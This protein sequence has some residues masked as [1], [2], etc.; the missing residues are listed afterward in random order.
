M[1]IK[2]ATP[3]LF[4]NG[5]AVE[6]AA[7]YANALGGTV[8]SLMRYGDMDNC[9]DADKERV[10][11]GLVTIGE[12]KVMLSDTHSSVSPAGSEAATLAGSNVRVA[13]DFDSPEEMKKAF[14]ALAVGG[15]VM[16]P[17]MEV[18]WGAFGMLTD[19]YEIC[20]M[21]NFSKKPD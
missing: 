5:Q 20:W 1:T 8:A 17:I 13:L 3:Y 14:A 19:K 2:A 12:T 11:H 6:A 16:A 18:P 4:F 9:P 21:F 15:T 10:M 7:F